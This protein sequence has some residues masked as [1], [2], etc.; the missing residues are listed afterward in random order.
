[1]AN[2]MFRSI[3]AQFPAIQ[4][5]DGNHEEVIEFLKS[6]NIAAMFRDETPARQLANGQTTGGFRKAIVIQYQMDDS[7][8]SILQEI[9]EEQWVVCNFAVRVDPVI[10]DDAIFR[11][12]FEEMPTE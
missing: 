5:H 4:Y 8:S 1:M 3:P 7:P 6:Q 10:Y 11:V 12:H 9:Y 2:L